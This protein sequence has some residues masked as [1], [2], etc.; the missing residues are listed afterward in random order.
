MTSDNGAS[1]DAPNLVKLKDDSVRMRL[2][3]G[4]TKCAETN[5]TGPIL[6]NKRAYQRH[7]FRAMR[8]GWQGE[9]LD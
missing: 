1:N 9:P 2:A 8:A 5:L 6:V 4:G 7:T 3:Y